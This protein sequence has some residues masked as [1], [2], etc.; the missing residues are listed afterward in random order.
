[1]DIF[2]QALGFLGMALVLISFQ[3]RKQ[4]TLIRIQLFDEIVF[5]TH[6]LLLGATTGAILNIIGIGR[7]FVFSCRER[8]WAQKKGWVPL[9]CGA[10]F[11]VYVLMFTVFGMPATAQNLVLELLPV[12]GSF[13][14]TI[15]FRLDNITM[16]KL[17]LV[18]GGTWIIYAVISSSIGG[19][20]TEGIGILSVLIGLWRL[21]KKN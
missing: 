16:R 5:A 15:G 12:V 21:K 2:V 11:A 20:L 3:F 13:A 14:T 18:N 1:M 10:Y 8:P 9:F 19:A 4:K 7:A 6:Y 17:A